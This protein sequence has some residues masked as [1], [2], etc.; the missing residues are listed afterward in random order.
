MCL[1]NVHC[2]NSVVHSFIHLSIHSFIHSFIHSLIH[3]FI[4]LSIHSFI[5]SFIHSFI[6]P[7]IH[8]FIHSLIHSSRCIYPMYIVSI[9]LST[10]Y[11]SFYLGASPIGI[12]PKINNMITAYQSVQYELIWLSDSNILSQL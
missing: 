3:S 7:F 5:Y 8:S 2:I 11:S 9:H 6:Y 12:N 1:S 4:H 10:I